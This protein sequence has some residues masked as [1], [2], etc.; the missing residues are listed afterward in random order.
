MKTKIEINGYEITIEEMEENIVVKAE[1]D[2]EV[3]EE[4]SLSLG[5]KV[6]YDE[7]NSEEGSEEDMKD[8]G[9]FSEEGEEGEEGEDDERMEERNNLKDFSSY[10]KSRS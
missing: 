7:D 1:L 2:D 9:E 8:F 5:E 6:D 4:F 10:I 3:I